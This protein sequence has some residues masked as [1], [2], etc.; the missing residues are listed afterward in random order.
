MAPVSMW[1]KINANEKAINNQIRDEW[2][3]APTCN[4]NVASN[5]KFNIFIGAFFMAESLI[6][7]LGTIWIFDVSKAPG[8]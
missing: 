4:R 7:C 8:K 6:D 2:V 1:P 3:P 5:G